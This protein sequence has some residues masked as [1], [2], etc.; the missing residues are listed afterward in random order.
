[1]IVQ[2]RNKYIAERDMTDRKTNE[3]PKQTRRAKEK[4]RGLGKDERK[5]KEQYTG[6]L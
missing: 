6:N 1:M 5:G 4:E 3:I 2:T